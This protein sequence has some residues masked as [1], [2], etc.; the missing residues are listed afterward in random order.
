MLAMLTA[1][2]ATKITFDLKAHLLALA[3]PA[4]GCGSVRLGAAAD[5]RDW[6]G[7]LIDARVARW[8]L[9]P[10]SGSVRDNPG[11]DMT[12][13]RVAAWPSPRPAAAL[14][15]LTLLLPHAGHPAAAPGSAEG[16]AATRGAA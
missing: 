9:H 7:T 1:A 13:A 8:L 10:D 3:Q 2:H 16:P 5:G 12:K 15:A 6:A 14:L 11:V 4:L